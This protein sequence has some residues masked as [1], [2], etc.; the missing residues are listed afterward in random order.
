MRHQQLL[1]HAA[2]A[3][4]AEVASAPPEWTGPI[5]NAEILSPSP[6][7]EPF[8]R[9]QRDLPHVISA[10][11]LDQTPVLFGELEAPPNRPAVLDA[12]RRYRNQAT[13]ARSWLGA[14]GPNLQL[15]L[16]GPPG[17]YSDPQWRQL[18]ATVEAD[19]R[20]CRKLVWLFDEQPNGPAAALFIQRTFL[21]RP[22]DMAP[23][24]KEKLDRAS[25]LALPRGWERAVD[26]E[27]DAEALVR[28]II[29]LEEHGE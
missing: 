2:Q 15:F 12:V 16:S 3:I 23:P 8:Q 11:W 5:L 18:A 13:I 7:G 27:T 21:A 17:A 29:R 1:L 14:T 25:D 10:A 4:G 28:E 26:E 19:D 6:S 24:V 20:I 9:Q 22:W